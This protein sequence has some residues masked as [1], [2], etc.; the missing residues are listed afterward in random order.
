MTMTLKENIVIE[1]I[2]ERKT[3]MKFKFRKELGHS[4]HLFLFALKL[5]WNIKNDTYRNIAIDSTIIEMRIC[6]H[7]F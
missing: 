4:Y 2:T 5:T 3:T 7:A 1:L 6:M